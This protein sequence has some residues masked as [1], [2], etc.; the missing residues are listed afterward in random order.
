MGSPVDTVIS[1]VQRKII[2]LSKAVMYVQSQACIGKAIGAGL[3]SPKSCML[4][5]PVCKGNFWV[6]GP[7]A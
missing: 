2:M 3:K 7:F 1:A 6:V 4:L 5:C